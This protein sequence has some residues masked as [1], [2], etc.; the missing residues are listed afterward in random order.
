MPPHFLTFITSAIIREYDNQSREVEALHRAMREA[1]TKVFGTDEAQWTNPYTSSE[2][3]DT[4][5]TA[6]S[7]IYDA[8]TLMMGR[9]GGSASRASVRGAGG[10]SVMFTPSVL[11]E[12]SY[13]SA[14]MTGH[15]RR[16]ASSSSSH[17]HR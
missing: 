14:R 2:Y 8:D 4:M 11:E 15:H 13:A 10:N 3:Q 5:D 17:I 9:T 6:A 12:S 1:T 16:D 7:G